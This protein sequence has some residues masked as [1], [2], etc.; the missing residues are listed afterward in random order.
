MNPIRILDSFGEFYS[1]F[2]EDRPIFIH[3]QFD[4]LR[5]GDFHT[6]EE[7]ARATFKM[8]IV[9][10][11]VPPFDK[12]KPLR[13]VVVT[14]DQFAHLIVLNN[15]KFRILS[16][17]SLE[18]KVTLCHTLLVDA[19]GR[20]HLLFENGTL[21]R[22]S[23]ND[24]NV[25][26]VNWPPPKVLRVVRMCA[27]PAFENQLSAFP[28]SA[29]FSAFIRTENSCQIT[30]WFVD[31]NENRVYEGPTTITL[32]YQSQY[33]SPF[34]FKQEDQVF[35]AFPLNE[36]DKCD[37]IIA[38]SNFY[39]GTTYV[40]TNSGQLLSVTKN[41]LKHVANLNEPPVRI[42][43]NGT[44]FIYLNA[45]GSLISPVSGF[46]FPIPHFFRLEEYNSILIRCG[47]SNIN[48][49]PIIPPPPPQLAFASIETDKVTTNSGAVWKAPHK[50]VASN[51]ARQKN[52]EFIIV[53]TTA[54]IHI[55]KSNVSKGDLNLLFE[56]NWE[57][58]I[59]AVAI[60][61]TNY[62]VAS[63]DNRVYV[64]SFVG[65]PYSFT[66][67]QSLCLALSLSETTLASG[68]TD[69]LFIL[70]SL[71]DRGPIFT[72][73]PFKS[74]VKSVMHITDDSTVVEWG[75]ATG[76]VTADNIQWIKLPSFPAAN[77][78]SFGSGLLA[79]ATSQSL[80]IYN[81]VQRKLIAK[82][83]I[84]VI[85]VCSSGNRFFALTIRNEL[86]ILYF[87]RDIT[88]DHQSIIDIDEPLAIAAVDETVYVICTKFIS[89]FDMRGHKLDTVEI[90][91]PPRYYG[92]ASRGLFVAFSRNVWYISRDQSTKR[93]P[94]DKGNITG[95]AV[96]DDDRFV[97]STNSR[98]LICFCEGLKVI[99]STI[100]KI[101]KKVSSL[102]CYNSKI[103][104]P[105]D[106]VL[107]IFDDSS[108]QK[109]P[110]PQPASNIETVTK[111]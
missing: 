99:F 18:D 36:I 62:A 76:L 3:Y 56:K 17:S 90:S 101:S 72:V 87:H 25:T 77:F 106:T 63:V 69:G 107:A 67:Q 111:D 73:N 52:E 43:T 34:F 12:S 15:G 84:R 104:G 81:F 98:L 61:S 7:I 35:A 91:N 16:S 50:I 24:T 82:I 109:W 102:K 37:D 41:G 14:E 42:E 21:I 80:G 45:D 4:L 30:T 40:A 100:T 65:E 103:D 60:S 6:L 83:P 54:S 10:V 20:P 93:I 58:A 108:I 51:S 32:S 5:V 57:S 29:S 53:A 86:I 64:S 96:I 47:L 22:L 1:A 105:I 23:R 49:F 13:F 55:I 46:T 71:K 19:Q 88:V 31:F 70:A 38:C 27:L 95:F 92:A 28:N 79:L 110:I 78:A 2:H 94:H 59:T 97:I 44:D 74:P 26:N 33:I 89:V 85:G 75:E 39:H 11:C 48:P 9:S 66:F 68:F 8:P